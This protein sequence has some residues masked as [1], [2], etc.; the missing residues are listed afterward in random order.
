M[1][2]IHSGKMNGKKVL[3]TGSGTG[4]GREEA[5]EFAR[6]GADVALHYA[7][8][9]EGA[10]SA[11][12][13]IQKAGGKAEAL[14]ADLSQSGEAERLATRA[15]DFLGGLDIL[16]SN[17]GITMNK[18]FGTVTPEQFDTVYHVNIRAPFFV[19]QTA[20]PALLKSENGVVIN[21]TSIHAYSA[22]QEHTVYAGTKGGLVAYTRTLAI[23]LAPKGI[24]VNAIAPGA[25]YVPNYDKAIPNFDIEEAGKNIPAGFVGLPVDIAR[26]AIFLASEEARYIVGQTVVVDGGTISW[27]PFS[28]GFRQPLGAHFGQGYVPGL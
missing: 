15:I 11:V 16:I 18:P 7:H 9:A 23:E 26:V 14:P 3:V 6:E 25:V 28:D 5:L 24:R 1:E 19:T 20:L 27:M 22:M 10:K 12:E 17:A 8:S 2:Q 4:I 21:I 13:E